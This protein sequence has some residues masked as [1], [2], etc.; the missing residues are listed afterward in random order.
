[1][2]DGNAILLREGANRFHSIRLSLPKGKVPTPMLVLSVPWSWFQPMTAK[3]MRIETLYYERFVLAAAL[4]GA[5][6]E[7]DR[8]DEMIGY[9]H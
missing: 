8:L 2:H 7:H 1:M 9:E 3:L 5:D 6:W 4:K